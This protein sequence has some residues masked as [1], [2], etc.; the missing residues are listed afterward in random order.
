[1]FRIESS[2]RTLPYCDGMKRRTF[3]QVGVAGMASVALP[4]VLRAKAVS[5]KMVKAAKD[6]SIILIWLDGGP[7]HMDMYD[8]KPDA[9][10]EYRG[11]WTPIKTNV[12]GIEISELFPRQAKIA[13]KFSIIR[14]IH[15]DTTHHFIASCLMLTGRPDRLPRTQEA[16]YPS[17]GSMATAV[18]GARTKGMPAYVALPHSMTVG[19]RPGHNGAAY[20]GMEHN[21]F[22]S[23]VNAN[24]DNVKVPNL[25]LQDGMTIERLEDRRGLQKKMDQLKRDMDT[26]GAFDSMDQFQLRAFD[27]VTGPAARKAFDMGSEDPALRER[28]GRN[29]WGQ[30]ALLARRLVEA[31]STFVPCHFGGWDNHWSIEGAY[32]GML[33]TVDNAVASLLEDLDDR[34]MLDTTMVIVCGEFSRTPKMNDGEG[35]GTPGRHHWGNSM[36]VLVAGG[37][38][39]GGQIVGSTDSRGEV[40]K[41]RPLL[42]G[43]LHATMMHVLGVDPKVSF[44][45]YSGRPVHA[46]DKGDVIGELV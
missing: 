27:M 9:P 33:P 42:P 34:G 19:L 39:R 38:L 15:N 8:M 1:M 36:S 30:N 7:S 45:D 21:P 32:R 14:S 35:R 12:S 41:D 29:G 26:T 22:D 24:E 10:I 25:S 3:L 43:D 40:P 23:H 13:D 6:T 16:A 44:L 2:G 5:A 20:L 37:G 11:I 18:T 28:Y 31:G 4:D 17:I 46:V